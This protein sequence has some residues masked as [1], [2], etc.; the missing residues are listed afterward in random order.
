MEIRLTNAR[1]SHFFGNLHYDEISG[2]PAFDTFPRRLQLTKVEAVLVDSLLHI[3]GNLLAINSRPTSMSQLYPSK[4]PLVPESNSSY[5]RPKIRQRPQTM[6]D[7][8]FSDIMKRIENDL[9]AGWPSVSSLGSLLLS[10]S[11][12]LSSIQGADRPCLS[13]PGDTD[14]TFSSTPSVGIRSISFYPSPS[15]IDQDIDTSIESTIQKEERLGQ[16]TISNTACLS[17]E[18]M[19]D[20]RDTDTMKSCEKTARG[21]QFVT[22]TGSLTDDISSDDETLPESLDYPNDENG[23]PVALVSFTF[24]V[25]RFLMG[26]FACILSTASTASLIDLELLKKQPV[27]NSIPYDSMYETVASYLRLLMSRLRFGLQ[28]CSQILASPLMQ[29]PLK[30]LEDLMTIFTTS[31]NSFNLSDRIKSLWPS[32]P[33]CTVTLHPGVGNVQDA[34]DANLWKPQLSASSAI[35][36]MVYLEA[37]L[38]YCRG[39]LALELTSI[40][41]LQVPA[42]SLGSLKSFTNS[43]LFVGTDALFI[44]PDVAELS[45]WQLVRLHEMETLAD[46]YPPAR[47]ILQIL[48]GLSTCSIPHLLLSLAISIGGMPIIS[49]W[50]RKNK[51]M[52]QLL[53]HATKQSNLLKRFVKEKNLI[54]RNAPT[55]D[56]QSRNSY[57]IDTAAS[58]KVSLPFLL[59]LLKGLPKHVGDSFIDSNAFAEDG[60]G[61]S[62]AHFGGWGVTWYLQIQ[63]CEIL[64]ITMTRIFGLPVSQTNH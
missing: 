33:L 5:S 34:S 50:A 18:G 64:G 3:C 56:Q 11:I 30:S 57:T 53:G 51:G 38:S 10:L 39:I 26:L 6:N 41:P 24:P 42:E 48:P 32:G 4:S 15:N 1:L 14:H 40:R 28:C 36:I 21:P 9:A 19:D 58:D 37:F 60:F 44:T 7:P 47:S 52:L 63:L 61:L 16:S 49:H 54:E 20:E 17:Q 25:Q 43:R 45:S 59:S 22:T 2:A 12:L 29:H 8:S 31:S 62:T 35:F 27:D 46:F 13:T 55:S 23:P